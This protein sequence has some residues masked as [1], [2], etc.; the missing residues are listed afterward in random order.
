MRYRVVT[1]DYAVTRP[2]SS[3]PLATT[4]VT[5]E[6]MKGMKNNAIV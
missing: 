2:T 3:P 4:A 1:M 6:H 5:H